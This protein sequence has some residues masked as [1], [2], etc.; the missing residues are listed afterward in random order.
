MASNPTHHF[1]YISTSRPDQPAI[2]Q[3][4]S[5]DEYLTRERPITRLG[6]DGWPKAVE[7]DPEAEYGAEVSILLQQL[8]IG[9]GSA[10]LFR[11]AR[12]V[13][14]E[15]YQRLSSKTGYEEVKVSLDQ[16]VDITDQ[17][18]LRLLA[19]LDAGKPD[20]ELQAILKVWAIVTELLFGPA[21]YRTVVYATTRRRARSTNFESVYKALLCAYRGNK[22]P[23]A[24][25]ELPKLYQW[26]LGRSR[27]Q[28]AQTTPEQPAPPGMLPRV[29]HT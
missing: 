5:L 4:A 11:T 24:E 13:G 17:D 18:A 26:A 8:G 19:D 27:K 23:D 28:M 20:G 1:P 22:F 12:M 7:P 10:T 9:S 3:S 14:G 15:I 6:K 29:L 16:C 2:G 25:V 21:A